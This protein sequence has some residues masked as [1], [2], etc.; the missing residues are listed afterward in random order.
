MTGVKKQCSECNNVNP[1][2]ANY[3][4]MCGKKLN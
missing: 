3:C 2:D 4:E 1:S